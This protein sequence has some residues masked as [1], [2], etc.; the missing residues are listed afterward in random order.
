MLKLLITTPLLGIIVLI[1]K[2]REHPQNT[3]DES[4]KFNFTLK[5]NKTFGTRLQGPNNM[6]N[7][8][9]RQEVGRGQGV[10]EIVDT[11]DVVRGIG[12][13]ITIIT[14]ILS[15][16]LLLKYNYNNIEFQF[17]EVLNTGWYT[18]TI[19]IDGLSLILTIL[20]T[21][22]FP[23][24]IILIPERMRFEEVKNM[25]IIL[26]VLE[27]IILLLLFSLDLFL[28]Y[29]L[30][31]LLLIPLFIIIG[32]YGSK[33]TII[34]SISEIE[35]VQEKERINYTSEYVGESKKISKTSMEATKRFFIYSLIGSLFMLI[36]IIILYYKFGSTNNEILQLK[37]YQSLFSL[38]TP[39]IEVLYKFFWITFFL[40]FAIKIPIFPF[41]SWL[42]LAHSEANTIG[43]ILLAAILL[44]IGTYGIFRY[45]L[46]FYFY[47]NSY[48]LPLV[49]TLSS[50]SILYAS[51]A[52][53]IQIDIKRIIAYS[54]IVHM[55]SSIISLFINDIKGLLGTAFLM[56]SHGL[57]SSGLFLLIGI[58][59]IRYHI[60]TF[61]YFSNLVIYMPIFTTLF[62]LYILNLLSIPFTSSFISELLIL[63]AIFKEN[64]FL[65]FFLSFT[66]FFNTLYSIWLF[67]RLSFG[68]LSPKYNSYIYQFKDVSLNEFLTLSP[69]LFFSIFFGL[70]PNSILHSLSL[71][72]LRHLLL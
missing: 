17:R 45:L 7:I 33:E 65:T 5:D 39:N 1:L 54:S 49:F 3:L 62:F 24:L 71:S 64:I 44:K 22:L 55:N 70:F 35:I 61:L 20:T 25:I 48:F 30:F 47:I 29:V 6:E 41:H 23:I 63:S 46:E 34:Q 18:F 53:L 11:S 12:E 50:L 21:M 72:L 57:I 60:R 40:T 58:L 42:P 38:N 19:G 68:R 56:I 13:G 27:S 26:L 69:F 32:R 4:Y 31:E 36:S 15:L 67:N 10:K 51:L 43:S 14:Y 9:I 8:Q 2:V 28:F 59:Y 52:T 66:I 37:N 16:I